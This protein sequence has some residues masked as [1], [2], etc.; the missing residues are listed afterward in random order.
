ME[1][2]GPSTHP[3]PDSSSKLGSGATLESPVGVG[4]AVARVA[5]RVMRTVENCILSVGYEVDMEVI[6]VMKVICFV[7]VCCCCCGEEDVIAVLMKTKS[8]GKDGFL[9]TFWALLLL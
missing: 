8:G 9:Y 3:T 1:G 7:F 4:V 2:A 6:D 5:M